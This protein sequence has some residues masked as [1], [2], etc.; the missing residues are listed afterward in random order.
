M[1]ASTLSDHGPSYDTTSR[2]TLAGNLDVGED[3]D[4]VVVYQESTDRVHHLNDS[5]ATILALCDGTRSAVDIANFLA[6]GFGLEQPP[7][8]ETLACLAEL[9]KEGV[10]C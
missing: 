5:A 9:A 6:D 1:G 8:D 10:G 4:G 2:P 3:L 7:L